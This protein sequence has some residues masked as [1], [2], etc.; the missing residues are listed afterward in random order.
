MAT[1]LINPDNSLSL[2]LNEEERS[3]YD[4]IPSGQLEEYITL[5]I[6]EKFSSSWR[7]R[8]ERLTPAQKA[9]ILAMLQAS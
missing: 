9:I 5:W 7:R 6:A 8:I 3:T 4:A 2:S 1:I